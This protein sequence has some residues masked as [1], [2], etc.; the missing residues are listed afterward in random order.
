[1]SNQIRLVISF[2][3]KPE[4]ADEVARQLG[5]RCTEV[6]KEPGCLQ[7]EVF[8][9][10]VEPRN[11]TLLERWTDQA[12]LH[13]HAEVNKQRAPLAA[14]MFATISQREDYEYARTR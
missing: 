7:F 13:S 10:V 6:L 8:R 14:E 2:V 3:A 12:A 11:F 1:L 5:E 9:S 4:H